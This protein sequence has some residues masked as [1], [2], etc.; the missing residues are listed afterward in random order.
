MPPHE[1]GQDRVRV[2]EAPLVTHV[3]LHAPQADQTP[4]TAFRQQL[5]TTFDVAPLQVAPLHAGA[6]LLHVRVSV[7]VTLP[8]VLDHAPVAQ[9]VQPPLTGQQSV[10]EFVVTPLQDDA[11]PH[12]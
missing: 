5:E 11:A 10:R 9:A 1:Y 3:P 2:T 7:R 4:L 12:P 8:Q 6:G